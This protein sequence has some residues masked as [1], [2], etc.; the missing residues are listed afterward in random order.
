MLAKTDTVDTDDSRRRVAQELQ[1]TR[2][3]E[4]NC[5]LWLVLGNASRKEAVPL[6]H[7]PSRAHRV[8]SWCHLAYHR[9]KYVSVK[10]SIP[11][12]ENRV[13][14]F[15]NGT[16][17]TETIQGTPDTLSHLTSRLLCRFTVD[18]CR[19]KGHCGGNSELK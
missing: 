5:S 11:T 17:H 15:H 8:Y 2:R 14:G 7:L 4:C 1:S 10:L 13:L 6:A 12:T 19:R 16:T 3:S 9:T 18:T